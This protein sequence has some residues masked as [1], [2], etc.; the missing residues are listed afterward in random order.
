[1]ELKHSQLRAQDKEA[2]K[3]WFSKFDFR[4]RNL[5]LINLIIVM[6]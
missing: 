5:Y 1:M 6:S 2:Y 4:I 3:D